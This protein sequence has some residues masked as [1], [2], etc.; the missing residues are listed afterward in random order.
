MEK[1]TRQWS[2]GITDYKE[3]SDMFNV[4]RTETDIFCRN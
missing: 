4:P 2:T 3:A 1:V